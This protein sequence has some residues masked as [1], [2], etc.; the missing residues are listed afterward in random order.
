[1][2][3]RNTS[4]LSRIDQMEVLEAAA[5]GIKEKQ[6]Y[7]LRQTLFQVLSILLRLNTA[8]VVS[9]KY[10]I[11]WNPLMEKRGFFKSIVMQNP[12]YYLKAFGE[13][14]LLYIE[15]VSEEEGV[16]SVTE[17]VPASGEL[18]DFEALREQVVK[19]LEEVIDIMKK[20]DEQ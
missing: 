3:E 18:F 5:A 19:A 10:M 14:T 4:A 12:T 11:L 2:K 16:V 20:G 9:T 17:A 6:L 13:I 8:H 7:Y 1:M 15:K